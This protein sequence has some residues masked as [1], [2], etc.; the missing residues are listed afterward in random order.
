MSLK[1]DQFHSFHMNQQISATK[2]GNSML[3]E[4]HCLKQSDRFKLVPVHFPEKLNTDL[5]FLH[6]STVNEHSMNK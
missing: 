1:I 6:N 4:F 2:V 3:E 5:I